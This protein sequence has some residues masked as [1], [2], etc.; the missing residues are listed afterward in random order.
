LILLNLIGDN[1][2]IIARKVSCIIT[3]ISNLLKHGYEKDYCWMTIRVVEGTKNFKV[4]R[5]HCDGKYFNPDKYTDLQTKFIMVLKG[6]GT[7]LIKRDDK[8][9]TIY[10]NH[11]E[12]LVSESRY[13]TIEDR[14]LLDI[15]LKKNGAEQ[16]QLNNDEGLLFLA[17]HSNCTIHS[18]PDNC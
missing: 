18:E 7:L 10:N 14:E 17:G 4:P 6:P 1:S 15:E 2:D 9:K 16:I 5:W 11:V 12:K 8:I 3:N 13:A